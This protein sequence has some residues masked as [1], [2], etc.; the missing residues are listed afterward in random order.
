MAAYHGSENADMKS[1][2][3]S[4]RDASIDVDRRRAIAPAIRHR[5][6]YHGLVSA[7]GMSLRRMSRVTPPPI[8]PMTAMSTM[9]TIVKLR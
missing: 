2:T 8:P 3:R 9:P 6:M 1:N 4:V 5:K 7:D